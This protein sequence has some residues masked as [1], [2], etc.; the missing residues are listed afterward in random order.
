MNIKLSKNFMKSEF[1]NNDCAV[2]P[3]DA[4]LNDDNN[5][6]LFDLAI[7]KMQFGRTGCPVLE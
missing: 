3:C 2:T 1:G 7:M 6:D 5:V 4:D